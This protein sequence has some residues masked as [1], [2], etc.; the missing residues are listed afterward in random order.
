V[1]QRHNLALV[2]YHPDATLKTTTLAEGGNVEVLFYWPFA[3][4]S[5]TVLTGNWTA[6]REGDSYVALRPVYLPP[7]KVSG[8]VAGSNY[9]WSDADPS[10]WAVIV[11]N[12]NVHGTFPQFVSLLDSSWEVSTVASE[13][14]SITS[15][16]SVDGN[17]LTLEMP[18]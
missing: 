4:F 16:I 6:S 1:V 11:G 8:V 18:L 14:E 7:D 2:G 13:D 3:S 15:Q 9:I 12:A 17:T 10:I 5:E